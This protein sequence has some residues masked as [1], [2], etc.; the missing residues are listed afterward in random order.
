MEGRKEVVVLAQVGVTGCAV[1][2]VSLDSRGGI[3]SSAADGDAPFLNDTLEFPAEPT[4][5]NIFWEEKLWVKEG[6][7]P[8]AW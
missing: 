2:V 8:R 1:W 4:E 7:S 3:H 5:E 6:G